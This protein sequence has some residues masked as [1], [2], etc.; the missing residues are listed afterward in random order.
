MR[1]GTRKYSVCPSVP[2]GAFT[3]TSGQ[4]NQTY[5]YDQF[6]NRTVSGWIPYAGQTPTS[7][8]SFPN[9]QW[10]AGNGVTYDAAGN[11]TGITSAN[12]TFTFD[13]ENRQTIATV[14]SVGTNYTY[15]GDGRRVI[16]S[17]GGTTTVFVYDASGHLAAEYGG[18][19]PLTGT[20]YLTDDHLG[21]T[22]MVTNSA[23]TVVSRFDYA[24][25]GEELVQ[26][27]DGRTAPYS[28]NQYPTATLDGTSQKFT[29]KER[30]AETGL[31]FFG[32]RYFSGAQGRFTSADDPLNDQEPSDPQS[33]NLY[34]YVRN[35]PLR[36]VDPSGQDCIT[37]TNQTDKSVTVTVASGN[38]SGKSA[39]Q[40][41]VAGTVNMSS[42]T[43][44]GT[45]IGFSYTSYDPNTTFGA[46]TVNLGPAPSDALSPFAQQTLGQAGNWASDGSAIRGG[47][48][49]LA[50][51]LAMIGPGGG[52]HEE[53]EPGG[54]VREPNESTGR[55]TPANLKEQ[56]ALE[57]AKSNPT[58]GRELKNIK[59]NDS[60]WPASQ[61][62][63][64]MEQKINGVTVHYVRNTNTGAVADFKFK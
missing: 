22:R 4:A 29:S 33:W 63:V 56:L 39:N 52:P 28:N 44:N 30:D 2:R 54:L 57:Q 16:K 43:Y 50:Q 17:V 19:N 47:L 12:R 35:N 32:A 37:A 59:M 61:G 13:A 58:A 36:N 15:D 25:F 26:G 42:L 5:G 11:Q 38:C 9:N 23:A 55:A 41:Y 64:K 62:W 27:I 53:G 20:T 3:E 40:T 49:G 18:T 46:G 31:D 14:N 8:A 60:R 10:A 34:S 51:V 21:S 6:G 48:L 24:P 1:G 45:S 7:G